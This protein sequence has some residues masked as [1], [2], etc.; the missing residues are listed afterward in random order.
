MESKQ[1]NFRLPEDKLRRFR[2][3]LALAGETQQEV[4]ERS[5]DGYIE[6]AERVK[7]A[8]ASR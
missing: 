4:L 7:P 3:A 2:A 6:R 1:T 5:V 8:K